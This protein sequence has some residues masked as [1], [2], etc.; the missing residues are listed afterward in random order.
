MT[1]ECD[2]STALRRDGVRR[3]IRASTGRDLPEDSSYRQE[4]GNDGTSRAIEAAGKPLQDLVH[5]LTISIE[6]R[7]PYTFD[8]Q[9]RVTRLAVGIAEE[10][11]LGRDRIDGLR[12]AAS[13]HDIGKIVIPLEILN[14]PARLTEA[15]FA[16]IKTHAQVGYEMLLPITF[17]WPVAD[18]VRQ[19]HERGDG[20]GYPCGLT[21]G[22]TLL[23]ARILAVADVLEA[24][25]SHRPY[26]A[27]LGIDAAMDEV[28]KKS[29][30]LYDTEVVEA[31]IR[32]LLI[33]KFR[34]DINVSQ[35]R[36]SANPAI[37]L[38]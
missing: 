28:S 21:A 13:V 27:A 4:P 24:M 7:D 26:R 23:E 10:I 19:H 33:K 16:L 29:A 8:H 35:N 32:L 12:L 37:P 18:I 31:C 11:G 17:S 22:Q 25:S 14:R 2:M 34:F 15:E 38:K 6:K 3:K 36:P 5:A 20:S 9:V 1:I 30:G